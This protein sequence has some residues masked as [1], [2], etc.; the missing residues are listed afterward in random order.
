MQ[1]KKYKEHDFWNQALK[2]ARGK[3]AEGRLY[4]AQIRAVIKVLE[5]KRDTGEPC[6]GE[7]AGTGKKRKSVPA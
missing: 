5:K 3:L 4:V 1:H 7:D 2:D 6:P